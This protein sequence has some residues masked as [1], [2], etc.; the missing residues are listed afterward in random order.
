MKVIHL[1]QSLATTDAATVVKLLFQYRCDY[2]DVATFAFI[3]GMKKNKKLY[4]F[5][6]KLVF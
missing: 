4:D 2:F 6:T 1:G 5:E 3:S